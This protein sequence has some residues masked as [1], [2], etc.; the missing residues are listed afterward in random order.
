MKIMVE[1][2]VKI[3]IEESPM[4]ISRRGMPRGVEMTQHE[5]DVEDME[6]HPMSQDE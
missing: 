6:D 1:E 2:G 5:Y 3:T 4:T